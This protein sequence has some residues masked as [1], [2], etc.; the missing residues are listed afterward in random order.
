MYYSSSDSETPQIKIWRACPCTGS[1]NH[2][3]PEPYCWD[4]DGAGGWHELVDDDGW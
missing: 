3:E 2:K 4:C 1:F